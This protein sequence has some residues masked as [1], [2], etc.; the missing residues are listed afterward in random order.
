MVD[1]TYNTEPFKVN[2]IVLG[3]L[4]AGLYCL[5]NWSLKI[6]R[7][8]SMPGKWIVLINRQ[9][10]VIMVTYPIWSRVVR[11]NVDK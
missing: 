5:F 8:E 3:F 2:D 9:D 11:S 1:G 6:R 10:E 4:L 7:L